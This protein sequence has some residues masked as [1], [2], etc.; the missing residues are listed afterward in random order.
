M[1]TDQTRPPVGADGKVYVM[2][3][4]AHVSAYDAASIT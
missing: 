1:S 4:E 2:D 3:A